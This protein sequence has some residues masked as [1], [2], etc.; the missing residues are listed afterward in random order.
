MRILIACLL[1]AAAILL[2]SADALAKDGKGGGPGGAKRSGQGGGNASRKEHVKKNHV[3]KEHVKREHVKQDHHAKTPKNKDGAK[4]DKH[5]AKEEKKLAKEER[6]RQQKTGEYDYD[7]HDEG[8]DDDDEVMD[9]DGEHVDHPGKGIGSHVREL[10]GLTGQERKEAIKRLQQEHGIA[11]GRF[12]DLPTTGGGGDVTDGIED[13]HDGLD[14][15][16]VE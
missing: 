14:D 8:I 16:D 12:K 5:A 11:K 7:D 13:T 1:C 6:R 15:E 9:D 10:K 4:Q 3:N 2:T